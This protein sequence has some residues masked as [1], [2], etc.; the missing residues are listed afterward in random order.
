MPTY[1]LISAKGT[2]TVDGE[3]ADAVAAAN[4]MDAELQ[5]AYGVT[6]ED[7]AGNTVAEVIDGEVSEGSAW[8][9]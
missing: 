2:R 5:P 7:A 9:E 1:R 4:A 8:V 3:Q 6:V